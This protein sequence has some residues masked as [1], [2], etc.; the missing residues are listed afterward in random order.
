MSET[1]ARLLRL[2]ALLQSRPGW[3]GPELA[4]RLAVTPRTI[5]NDVERLR[6]L[7]YTVD[8]RPGR[9]GGYRLGMPSAMQPLLLDDEEAV[10]VAVGLRTAA[11]GTVSGLEDVSLRALAKLQ[12]AVP[13]HVRRRIAALH[14]FTEPAGK[15]GPA[16]DPELLV[17]VVGA[18]RDAEGLRF[19]YR[20]H[21]GSETLRVV[22]PHRLVHL[23]RYWYLA[24]WDLDRDGWRTFRL[25]RI[26]GTPSAGSRFTPRP[27][28]EGGFPAYVARGRSNARDRHQVT[29]LLHA[30]LAVAAE[31][32]P[33]QS[34]LLEAVD[35]RTC[36][37]HTGGPWLGGVAVHIAL[38]GL[39]FDVVSPPELA[40]VVRELAERLARAGS[41]S[42]RS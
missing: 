25:D 11:G 40:G 41:N 21:D 14:S 7:G 13:S 34:G 39:D 22:E 2:L 36:L 28:P 12:Q 33:P 31:R 20:A 35:E 3:P 23:G 10:A 6:D 16:V 15:G 4:R 18:C 26:A 19:R 37:L 30:P 29:V 8:A 32:V 38:L 1:A 27:P 24:A 9:G 5:R 17:T 42:A